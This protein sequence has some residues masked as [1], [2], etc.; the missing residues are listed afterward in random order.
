MLVRN[1]RFPKTEYLGR[2]CEARDA[3]CPCR[4]CYSPHDFGSSNT[5]GRWVV[6]MM[7]A[8][9]ER[10]GCPAPLPEPEHVHTTPRARKCARCK[11]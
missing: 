10:G 6:D 4:S 11:A 8:T 3:D 5:R 2:P 9:R 7:C 1:L